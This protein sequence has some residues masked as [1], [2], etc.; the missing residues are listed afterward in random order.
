MITHV[1][2]AR[3]PSFSTILANTVDFHLVRRSDKPESARNFFL[4]GFDLRLSKF[5][6]TPTALANQMVM[7]LLAFKLFKSRLPISK[8]SL[9]C[10][11]A[12]F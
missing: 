6:D 7:M 8:V 11:A 12:L 5:D 9:F 4:Q 10:Q 2:G 3:A 1:R